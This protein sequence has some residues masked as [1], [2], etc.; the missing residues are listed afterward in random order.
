MCPIDI[1]DVAEVIVRVLDNPSFF[2]KTLELTGCQ[3]LSIQ[4]HLDII[5]QVHA[6]AFV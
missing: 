4:E 3:Q 1:G 6:V 2:G 5:A